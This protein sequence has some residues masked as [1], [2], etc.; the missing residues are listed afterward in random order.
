L[1]VF[2]VKERRSSPR[3]VSQR[4]KP[5]VDEQNPVVRDP[6]VRLMLRVK[7]GDADAFT[8][9]VTQYQDRLVNVLYHLVGDQELAEDLAQ[10]VFLRVYR[11]KAGYEPTAKFSTWLFRIANNLA[12]NQRRDR[13]RRREVAL[14]VHESG[15]LGARPAEQLLAEKSSVLPTRNLDRD[16]LRRMVRDAL[17]SL[18]ERQKIAV[19]LH[20][21]EEMSYADI[22]TTLELTPQAVKSLLARARENL[23][24]KLEPYVKQSGSGSSRPVEANGEDE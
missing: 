10:E 22:G 17:D 14:N 21:Y 16:E 1:L 7:A 12:S 11:A 3:T 13:G 20:K 23:R 9:L 8:Q 6:D 18:N 15:P 2:G 5:L 24:A 4:A 19:L